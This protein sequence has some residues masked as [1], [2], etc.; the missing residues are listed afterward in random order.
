MNKINY[1]IDQ[2]NDAE[3]AWKNKLYNR[4]YEQ[5]DI[6]KLN[7]TVKE[8]TIIYPCGFYDVSNTWSRF[9]CN[10]QIPNQNDL[11]IVENEKMLELKKA[12]LSIEEDRAAGK[13]GCTLDEFETYLN[14]VI[15]S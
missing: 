6:P 15:E 12:L 3:G 7:F 14:D 8:K 2:V 4:Y 9:F 11:I 10:D 5:N 13:S 1:T